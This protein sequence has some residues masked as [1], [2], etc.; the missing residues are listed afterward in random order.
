MKG[1][2]SVDELSANMEEIYAQVRQEIQAA[3]N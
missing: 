2:V 3:G 1:E